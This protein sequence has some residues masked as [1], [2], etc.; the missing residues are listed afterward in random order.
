MTK[1]SVIIPAYNEERNIGKTIKSV[2]KQNYK[3]LEIILVDDCSRDK[4]S[5]VGKKLGVKV[6]RNKINLG[7]AKT[8]NRGIKIARGKIVIT[9]HADCELVGK[10]WIKKI[11]GVFDKHKNVAAVTGNIIPFFENK[12]TTLDKVSL[13]FLGA[14]EKID[15]KNIYEKDILTN[16]CDAYKKEALKKVNFF[17]ER[18]KTSGEDIDLCCKLKKRKYRLM[19][20]PACRVRMR[21]SSQQNSFF[22]YLKKR[23][24]YGKVIPRLWFDHLSELIKNKTW[25]LSSIPYMGYLLCLVLSLFNWLFILP[26]LIANIFLSIRVSQRVVFSSF[27]TAFVLIPI[28]TFF[29]GIGIIYGLFLINKKRI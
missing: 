10:D 7:L 4:T 19:S 27:L 20:N 11:I 16:K 15:S 17:N 1:V 6:L 22:K 21:F 9:L 13:Y 26:V 29:W 18:F 8:L 3:N 2:L 24:T 23:I 28:Y 12:M 5:E 14:Y 25:I